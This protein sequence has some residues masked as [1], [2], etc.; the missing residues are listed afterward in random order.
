MSEGEAGGGGMEAKK[1]QEQEVVPDPELDDLLDGKN[2]LSTHKWNL[3]LV[4][5]M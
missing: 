4:N 2:Y 3:M 5:G 1:G